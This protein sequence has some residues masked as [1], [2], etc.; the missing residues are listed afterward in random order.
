MDYFSTKHVQLKCNYR[1]LVDSQ[2]VSDS[3]PLMYGLFGGS[4]QALIAL[5]DSVEAQNSILLV[6][7]LVLSSMHFSPAI[8][9]I[10]ADPRLEEASA[11]AAACPSDILGRV[12]HDGRF[13]A[14]RSGPGWHHV[15]DILSNRSVKDAIM[16]YLHQLDTQ[17][18]ELLSNLSRISVLMLCAAHKKDR[19]AFDLHLS[20]ALSW[21][22]S[23][24]TLLQ[25]CHSQQT[26]WLI[27][28]VWLLIILVYITQLRPHLDESLLSSVQGMG[29]W[30][31]ILKS[32]CADADLL[33]ERYRDPHYLQ[34][35]R[36]LHFLGSTVGVSDSLYLKA[37]WKLE[38]EWRGW[39]GLGS[40]RET[41]LN[42]RL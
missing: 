16:E 21:I 31:E 13:S 29:S 22:H 27:R 15:T 11:A 7:S 26:D 42:I 37:A 8:H 24:Q 6:Q 20:R 2:L 3:R 28:G 23:L 38:Q 25:E 19:P 17:D 9:E 4:G 18:P 34:A 1:A 10:L 35:L 36:S 32:F 33:Q 30:E 12:A 41:S 14:G 5:G 40:P 39:T